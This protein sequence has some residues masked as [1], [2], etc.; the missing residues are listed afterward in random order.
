VNGARGSYS[1]TLLEM[2]PESLGSFRKKVRVGDASPAWGRLAAF[3][4]ARARI[5]R[6]EWSAG[7]SA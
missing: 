3:H 5:H 7:V 4:S 6:L 2:K 1:L